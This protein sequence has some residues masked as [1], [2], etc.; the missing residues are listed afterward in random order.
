MTDVRATI[1]S[2]E[3]F[4]NSDDTL[5]EADASAAAAKVQATEDAFT[6]IETT[7]EQTAKC[8]A[9]IAAQA[10]DA[11]AGDK[12]KQEKWSRSKS[13]AHACKSLDTLNQ[14]C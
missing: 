11:N 5:V 9:T 2:G 10:E 6:K 12:T 7:P 4:E 1:C 14:G 8:E 3:N 13:Y